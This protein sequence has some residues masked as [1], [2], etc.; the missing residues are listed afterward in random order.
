MKSKQKTKKN[1]E[2]RSTRRKS[3]RKEKKKKKDELTGKLEL[4]RFDAEEFSRTH[5]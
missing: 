1:P 2:N 3:P 4:E 5:C